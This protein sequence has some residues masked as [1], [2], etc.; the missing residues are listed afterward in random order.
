MSD[1]DKIAGLVVEKLKASN[2]EQRDEEFINKLVAKIQEQP[3]P[4]STFSEDDVI[5]LRDLI[6]KRKKLGKGLA[7]L[8]AAVLLMWVKDFYSLVSP[9][10]PF[11][12]P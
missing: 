2:R 1:H 8:A 7:W 3:A 11:G 5:V 6:V 12:G 4:C 10:L 9:Y